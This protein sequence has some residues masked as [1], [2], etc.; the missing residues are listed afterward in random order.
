MANVPFQMD[1]L[2]LPDPDS[3]PQGGVI[4]IPTHPALCTMTPPHI[5]GACSSHPPT[6]LVAPSFHSDWCV[7]N[8]CACS[9]WPWPPLFFLP[10][11]QPF[12]MG[13]FQM[14]VLIGMYTHTHTASPGLA[15]FKASE[16]V[17][18]LSLSAPSL[19]VKVIPTPIIH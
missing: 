19:C 7:C 9:D 4:P 2:R 14:P 13:L 11:R 10:Y 15:A 8:L 17:S 1:V 18:V 16:P 6:R 12:L 3:Q 5:G